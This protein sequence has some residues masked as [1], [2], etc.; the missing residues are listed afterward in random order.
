MATFATTVAATA[1][2]RLADDAT[3]HAAAVDA[4]ARARAAVVAAVQATPGPGADVLAQ[5]G[6]PG[7]AVAPGPAA[8]RV[9][10]AVTASGATTPVPPATLAA[11]D[12]CCADLAAGSDGSAAV[13]LRRIRRDL[14]GPLVVAVAGAA[15]SG[16]STLVNALAGERLAPAGTPTTAP[17]R[18]LPAGGP[19]LAAVAAFDEGDEPVPVR[20]RDDGAVE[21]AADPETDG[22]Y[23]WIDVEVPLRAPGIVLVD[24]GGWRLADPDRSAAAR[25]LTRPR[26]AWRLADA[27]VHVIVPDAFLPGAPGSL[28]ALGPL[29]DEALGVP[30][31][32]DAV[33]VV[34]RADELDDGG[35][36]ALGR[37]ARLAAELRMRPPFLLTCSTVLAVSGLLGEAAARLDRDDV[38]TLTELLEAPPD[39]LAR[40]IASVDAFCHPARAA[41]SV[42]RRHLLVSRLGL[43]GVRLALRALHGTSGA[44]GGRST[45]WPSACAPGRT[46]IASTPRSPG[47]SP[48][49]ATTSR[50]PRPWPACGAWW[51]S[52]PPGRGLRRRSPGSAPPST[53]WSVTIPALAERRVL[54]LVAAGTVRLSDAEV[55]EVAR[56]L[57][58]ET[59]AERLDH[60]PD[61]APAELREQIAAAQRR[62]DVLASSPANDGALGD[63]CAAVLRRY[64][65]DAAELSLPDEH[66]VPVA[67]RGARAISPCGRRRAR[68]RSCR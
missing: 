57:L 60:P 32:R 27:V 16:A 49:T 9:T 12:R 21:V 11:L 18:Y 1:S 52:W 40:A 46:S 22:P 50:R 38:A 7:G 30:S 36:D 5:R 29:L 68:R 24:A 56:V 58:G 35:R 19:G 59:V 45:S 43:S 34:G 54:R 64:D 37:A 8:D 15:R 14:H 44:I 63:V 61:A 67:G 20:R 13:A 55:R 51:R 17:V 3:A 2:R 23:R 31:A 4:A 10:R 39:E 41:V 33:A 42:E 48:P 65:A 66:A 53:R 26:P 62:W 6:C 28:R 25:P 47:A